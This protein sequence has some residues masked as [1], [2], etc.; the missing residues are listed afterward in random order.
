MKTKFFTYNQNNSGG[1]FLISESEGI[2]EYVIIEATDAD[3][4]N[5]RAESIGIYFD[6]CETGSDCPCCGDR[7]YP[8]DDSDGTDVPTIYGE[9]VETVTKDWFQKHVYIHYIDGTV[10]KVEFLEKDSNNQI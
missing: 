3:H 5:A 9:P 2:A 1:Q 4:A 7:W 6:G 8:V 10:K